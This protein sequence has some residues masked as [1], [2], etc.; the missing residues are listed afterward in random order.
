LVE[1]DGL[2]AVI[3]DH[4]LPDG[5]STFLCERLIERGIPFLMYSGFPSLD[6]PCK[7]APHLAKPASPDQLLEAMESLVRD[8]KAANNKQ[9]V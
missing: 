5:D 2:S 1:H 3:L 4:A 8:S 9:V 6:G 7:G